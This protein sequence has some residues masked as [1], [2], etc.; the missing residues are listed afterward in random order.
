M[1]ELKSLTVFQRA[2]ASLGFPHTFLPFTEITNRS[3]VTICIDSALTYSLEEMSH[4]G[5]PF[6]LSSSSCVGE[7]H[8]WHNLVG[9]SLNFKL[10]ICLDPDTCMSISVEQ[11]LRKK[12][13][14][15]CT[16]VLQWDQDAAP[17]WPGT[18]LGTLL[19]RDSSCDTIRQ[20]VWNCDEG[21]V[22]QNS[23][24]KKEHLMNLSP[25]LPAEPHTEGPS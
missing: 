16:Y 20:P 5:F 14:P 13:Q 19:E 11:I 2:E 9:I 18:H 10:H 21:R 4:R 12:S 6:R 24:R 8:V 7:I 3:I 15:W 22:K 23:T 17:C 25:S 1:T